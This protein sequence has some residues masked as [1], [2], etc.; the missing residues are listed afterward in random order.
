[1]VN[2]IQSTVSGYRTHIVVQLEGKGRYHYLGKVNSYN[3]FATKGFSKLFCL[4]KDV[5]IG[6]KV[7]TVHKSSY[8]KLLKKI[9]MEEISEDKSSVTNSKD[10]SKSNQE[11]AA[12][13]VLVNKYTD[14]S[15]A[16]KEAEP[17]KLATDKSVT[18]WLTKSK[19]ENLFAKL[20]EA[21]SGKNADGDRAVK[22][23]AKGAPLDRVYY[24]RGERYGIAYKMSKNIPDKSESFLVIEGA[25][26]IHAQEKKMERVVQVLKE[27]GA[28]QT[29][30][31]QKL[32][33]SRFTLKRE[34]LEVSQKTV[35]G[36]I[37]PKLACSLF[38][39]K[40]TPKF[41]YG[42]KKECFVNIKETREDEQ[43]IELE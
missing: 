41:G 10:F 36:F 33:G 26:L 40:L 24:N 42:A 27:A 29:K 37:L 2:Y 31:G 34:I 3:N 18:P 20:T 14:F 13:K 28:Q 8:A 21:I 32:K 7:R 5:L 25:P 17:D 35:W 22:L 15:D 23:I 16:L 39:P 30:E 43:I 12:I 4:S 1:M 19:R 11:K 9:G 6:G 38:P